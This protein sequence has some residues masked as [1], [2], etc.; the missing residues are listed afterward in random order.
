[1]TQKSA[2]SAAGPHTRPVTVM[3]IPSAK[4]ATNVPLML[5]SPPTRTT[6]TLISR[7]ID[8]V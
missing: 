4:A 8:P 7:T 6:T 1:V 3:T 5:P 2:V